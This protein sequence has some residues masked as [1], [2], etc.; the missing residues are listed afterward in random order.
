MSLVI[1]LIE[2]VLW[3][4]VIVRLLLLLPGFLAFAG[5]ILLVLLTALGLIWVF[6]LGFDLE[7][8][9][10]FIIRSLADFRIDHKMIALT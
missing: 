10:L 5:S 2:R 6:L 3:C 1:H 9:D 8:C 7:Y 4:L